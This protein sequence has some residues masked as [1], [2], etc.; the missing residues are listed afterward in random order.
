MKDI[1]ENRKR[2]TLARKMRLARLALRENGIIWCALFFAYYLTS[3]LAHRAFSAMDRWRSSRNIPGIN[4][5]ALNKEIWEAWNWDAAG[6]E[7]TRS[8]DWKQSLIRC[9]LEQEI[10]A[11]ASVLE[12][13]P[14]GG[15]WTAALLGRARTYTGVDI[16]ASCV[17]HC[18]QRFRNDPRARF[19]VGTGRDLR[20]VEKATVD[21]IWS[22]DV[23]VHINRAEVDAY[24]AEFARVLR[25]RGVGI[26]HHGGV[27]GASGGWRSN[28]TAE[29]FLRI[30][31]RHGL[32][33]VRS[34]AHWMDGQVVHDLQYGDQITVFV[35]PD[36]TPSAG[37]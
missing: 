8:E 19:V 7:W 11:D 3:A 23:F 34:V 37:A 24:A 30:L 18:R 12:I 28:L 17:E 14:G 9:V 27:G 2:I 33:P 4:S 31:D 35:K 16:S 13:G 29:A 32:Q 15:R 36:I 5:V 26:V 6:D 22:F 10:P 25:P 20:A 1:V 21:A